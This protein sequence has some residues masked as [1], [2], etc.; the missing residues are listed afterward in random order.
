MKESFLKIV[1]FLLATLVL[2]ST[3]SFTVEKHFCGDFLVDV[4]FTGNASDCEIKTVGHEAT[5][6]NCCKDETQR[7][8]GQNQ[9]QLASLE[10]IS[11]PQ[12]QF[13]LSY[14][15]SYK[16]LFSCL[17]K[18]KLIFREFSPLEAHKDFQV[19]YQTFLI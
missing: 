7:I 16:S 4:S 3:M 6:K 17:E 9:L 13:L 8:E 18:E 1:S 14:I 19:I 15:Y 10:K 5:M 12:E 11:F 2:F